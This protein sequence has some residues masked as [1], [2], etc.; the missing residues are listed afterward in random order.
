MRRLFLIIATVFA[1]SA[2]TLAVAPAASADVTR[3][4][5]VVTKYHTGGYYRA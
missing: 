1:I 5:C 2:G 4:N 3:D